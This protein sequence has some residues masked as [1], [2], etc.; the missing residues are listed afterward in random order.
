MGITGR[1]SAGR[2]PW[3]WTDW[4]RNSHGLSQVSADEV[5]RRV[6]HMTSHVSKF[7]AFDFS[8][9]QTMDQQYKAH[10][11]SHAGSKFD[12]KNGKEKFEKPSSG[13]NEKVCGLFGFTQFS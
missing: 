2:R 5:N 8:I 6:G 1:K 9:F 12:K 3:D 10:R 4:H 11:P 13:F 7:C